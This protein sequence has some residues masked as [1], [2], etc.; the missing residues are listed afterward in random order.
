MESKSRLKRIAIYIVGWG[1]I[2]LGILGLVLP[3]LQ[4]IIFLLIGLYILSSVSPR[5]ARM[6][7]RLRKRFPRI[8]E[9][10][11]RARPRAKAVL[12][13]IA[14]KFSG[15]KSKAGDAH[16]QVFKRKPRPSED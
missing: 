14:E 16:A 2:V 7:I 10:F 8:S 13:R 3:I 4:G 9:Q 15:A 5:A 6:L 1:F 12:A 11:E